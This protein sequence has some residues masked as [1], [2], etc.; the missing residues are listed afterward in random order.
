LAQR[1]KEVS[2]LQQIVADKDT[3]LS[4]AQKVQSEFMKKQRELNDARR[5]LDITVEKK[6]QESLVFVR[7]KAK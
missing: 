5:E 7:H 1:A 6:V 3:K 2:E 4:E